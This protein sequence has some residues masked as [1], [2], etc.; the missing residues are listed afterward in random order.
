[1]EHSQLSIPLGNCKFAVS[2]DGKFVAVGST[3]G[4]L[5]VFNLKSGEFVEAYDEQHSEP[6]MCVD[7]APGSASTIATIDKLGLLY[8]WN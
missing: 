4:L 2:P 8:I 7:W 3:N 1:M 5:F 6:I